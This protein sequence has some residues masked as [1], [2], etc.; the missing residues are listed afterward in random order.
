M[1]FKADEHNKIEIDF[2]YIRKNKNIKYIKL[3]FTYKYS[4]ITSFKLSVFSVV[5]LLLV[6][7]L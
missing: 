5:S 2:W 1:A 4:K 6:G 7:V 3:N